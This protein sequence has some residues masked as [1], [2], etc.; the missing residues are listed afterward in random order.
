MSL[1]AE[2]GLLTGW[3]YN[4]RGGREVEYLMGYAFPV[5]SLRYNNFP[6]QLQNFKTIALYFIDLQIRHKISST[7]FYSIIIN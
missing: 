3:L 4:S 1:Y 5:R 7:E 2:Y 6:R